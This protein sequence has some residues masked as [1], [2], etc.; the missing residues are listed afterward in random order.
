MTTDAPSRNEIEMEAENN[1]LRARIAELEAELAISHGSLARPTL[2]PDE[3]P[4]ITHNVPPSAPP[5]DA[6][7]ADWNQRRDHLHA[8][9]RAEIDANAASEEATT[10]PHNE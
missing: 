5:H 8:A 10:K 9:L 1:L 3:A 6:Q 7:F 2:T 4:T